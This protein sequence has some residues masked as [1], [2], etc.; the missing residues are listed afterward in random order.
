MP[1]SRSIFSLLADPAILNLLLVFLVPAGAYA[2]APVGSNATFVS[3]SLTDGSNPVAGLVQA[4][5]G[6]LYGT[7]FWGGG[8]NL[9]A[10]FKIAPNGVLTT[11]YSFCSQGGCADGEHP[12][13]ELVQAGGGSFYGT[14]SSG[15]VN[16]QGTIFKITPRGALTTIYS[17]C[18]QSSCTDGGDPV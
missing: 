10:I 17:F 9:G 1:Q 18:S 14:T 7:T 2:Q 8:A 5:N 3:F 11:L 15:G 13:A 6:Y 4:H 12:W 16:G